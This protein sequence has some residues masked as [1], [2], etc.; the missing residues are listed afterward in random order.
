MNYYFIT[1][2]H[3]FSVKKVLNNGM[4][5]VNNL[6]LSN[7]SRIINSFFS[8]DDFITSIG[9]LEYNHIC[10]GEYIYSIND[11][12]C[13]QGSDGSGFLNQQLKLVQLFSNC[14]WLIKDNSVNNELGF[15]LEV[16]K[17]PIKIYSNQ[18]SA[19]FV[20]AS[21]ERLDV[22][23]TE[24]EVKKS[25]ELV[26]LL[27]ELYNLDSSKTTPGMYREANRIHRFF[28]FLQGARTQNFLPNRIALY[29]TMLETL[30]STDS[31]EIS[32]KI[33]ERTS[34]IIEKTLDKRQE[35][36]DIIKNAYSVRSASV[37]GDNLPKKFRNKD[38]LKE[39]SVDLDDILR[40]LIYSIIN[41]KEMLN[42]YKLDNKNDLNNWFLE[43]TLK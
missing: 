40:R 43:L 10:S 29:C 35:C 21:G 16:D 14:L 42:M 36:F 26:E 13:L 25:V 11:S 8:N 34:K 2:I 23:F 17:N 32:H 9:T 39:L 28:Y 22:Q 12:D 41:D 5:I 1:R 18:M 30:L 7:G 33:S 38:K 20:N 4:K 19:M 24:E 3:H 6:R 27:F 15:L 37:H 31:I